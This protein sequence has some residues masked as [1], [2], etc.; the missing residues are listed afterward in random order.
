MATDHSSR[1][2]TTSHDIDF[3]QGLCEFDK[4]SRASS[5]VEMV[6]QALC[7]ISTCSQDER[8]GLVEYKEIMQAK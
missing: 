5:F 1:N 2:R 3:L 7:W 4:H 6:R 8:I